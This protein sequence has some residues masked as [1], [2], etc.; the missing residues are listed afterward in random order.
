M[1]EVADIVYVGQAIFHGTLNI[2][3]VVWAVIG[4]A[5]VLYFFSF[6]L[7]GSAR[8][9]WCLGEWS[10]FG[11]CPH[12]SDVE[13]IRHSI[14]S[15][16]VNEDKSTQSFP[17]LEICGSMTRLRARDDGRLLSTMSLWFVQAQYAPAAFLSGGLQSKRT[18]LSTRKLHYV[19]TGHRELEQGCLTEL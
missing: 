14:I 3:Q 5:S 12:Q 4:N 7:L 1:E 11:A 10:L 9:R 6:L 8:S 15:R 16:V 17:P 13:H 2:P 18:T 19:L